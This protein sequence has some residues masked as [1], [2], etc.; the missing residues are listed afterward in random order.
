M[1]QPME[2]GMVLGGIVLI[3]TQAVLV[4]VA[5]VWVRKSMRDGGTSSR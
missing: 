3:L 1:S 4:V 5:I 2:I